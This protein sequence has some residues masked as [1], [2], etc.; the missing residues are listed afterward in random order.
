MAPPGRKAEGGSLRPVRGRIP[1]YFHPEKGDTAFLFH[2]DGRPLAGP[3]YRIYPEVVDGYLVVRPTRQDEYILPD[4]EGRFLRKLESE[5]RRLADHVYVM[6]RYE[7]RRPGQGRLKKYGHF[8]RD[9]NPFTGCLFDKGPHA[10]GGLHIRQKIRVWDRAQ[11]VGYGPWVG[12]MKEG[13]GEDFPLLD[14]AGKTFGI[15]AE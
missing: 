4:P 8:D 11:P 3:C 9:L 1:G 2:V 14:A 6:A 5:P 12:Y 7:D 13:L 10:M 15:K